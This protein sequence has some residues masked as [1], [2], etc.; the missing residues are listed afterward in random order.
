MSVILTSCHF[1]WQVQEARPSHPK[2]L[3]GYLVE[4]SAECTVYFRLAL[5]LEFSLLILAGITGMYSL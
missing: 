5:D 4:A 3:S 1:V 2:E